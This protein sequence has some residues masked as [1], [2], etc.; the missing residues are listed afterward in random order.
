M[1][2]NKVQVPVNCRNLCTIE[3][4]VNSLIKQETS[5]NMPSLRIKENVIYFE[6]PAKTELRKI[7]TEG[8]ETFVFRQYQH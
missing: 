4:S 8:N 1:N 3:S 2:A 7:R 6:F 5:S